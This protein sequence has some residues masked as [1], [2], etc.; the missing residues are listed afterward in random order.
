M[1]DDSKL[2]TLRSNVKLDSLQIKTPVAG[3]AIQDSTVEVAAAASVNS[4]YTMVRVPTSARISGLSRVAFDDL[5]STGAPT[6]DIGFKPV[7][8]NFTASVTALNDG[9]D[10]ATAAGTAPVIKDIANYG[11]MVWEFLGL[12][13][14]PQ[15]FADVTISILD[16]AANTGGTIT[17]SLLYTVD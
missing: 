12:A 6:I 7:G 3:P 4:L 1:A 15:G 13:A 17:M 9:I 16:A 5:A 11:K 14:D 10:V 8:T 2:A